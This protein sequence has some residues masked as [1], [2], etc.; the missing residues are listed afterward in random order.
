MKYILEILLGL[1]ILQY[2]WA[3]GSNILLDPYLMCKKTRRLR[4][5]M[6][7]IC[8]HD[9]ALLKEIINGINL[10]FRECEFQFRNRRWNCTAL[11]KSMRKI[12]MRDTRETGF[13]NAITSAGVTYAV[14]KACTL[15][16]LIECSC[17]RSHSRRNGGQPQMVNA[18]TAVAALERQQAAYEKINTTNVAKRGRGKNRRGR[19]LKNIKFPEG[20]WEWGGCSDNVNFGFRHSRVFLDSRYRRRSD[21]RT[22]VKLH[23]NRAGRL[24]IRDS[25]RLE[26]KCHGLSGSCT[27]KTCWLKMPP[28]R[29]VAAR[30][31]DKFDRASKVILRNDGNSYMPEIETL[32][33]PTKYD[34]VYSDDS[35]DFCE[36]NM[37]TGSVGTQERECNATSLSSDSCEQLCCNRG[38]KHRI[39]SEWINCKCVF[40]WCCEVTCEK[41]LEKRE[42]NTCL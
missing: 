35:P 17:D 19:L 30:L 33:Q 5:K 8:R 31:R 41:C 13:V 18:V 16:N 34:L 32:K 37:R 27:V 38:Y 42:I 12:L 21:L 14:T 39:V 3:E 24:T 4:G 23:N 6:A 22:M 36:P 10:G 26:C 11:R 7:E 1:Y 2:I 9:S 15:G 40:K 28:F 29:E 20:E 25:M